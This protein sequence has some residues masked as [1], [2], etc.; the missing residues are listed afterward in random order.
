MCITLNNVNK[1]YPTRSRPLTHDLQ[2]GA[3]AANDTVEEGEPS[4]APSPE[5]SPV[6]R[7][8]Q[9]LAVETGQSHHRFYPSQLSTPLTVLGK[10]VEHKQE[11]TGIIDGSV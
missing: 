5:S 1:R 9:C 10:W 3:E 8:S 4:R 7:F 6:V 11:A 2:R